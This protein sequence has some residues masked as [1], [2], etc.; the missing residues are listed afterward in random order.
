MAKP[1]TYFGSNIEVCEGDHVT[2]KS[3]MFWRGWKK[4]RVSYVPGISKPHQQLEDN[5]LSWVGVSGDDGTFRG[6]VVNP[7][8]NELKKNI[9]FSKR[10]TGPGYITPHEI[11]EEEW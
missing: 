10:T 1:I 6:I 5:D 3:M 9:R 7:D 8:D 11:K 4:G 2:Y